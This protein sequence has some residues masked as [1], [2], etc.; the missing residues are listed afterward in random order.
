MPICCDSSLSLCTRARAQLREGLS[1]K[2]FVCRVCFQNRRFSWEFLAQSVSPARKSCELQPPLWLL[3]VS[4]RSALSL[5]SEAT[6]CVC[7]A[8][9]NQLQVLWYSSG[10]AISAML[11]S[12][13]P[14]VDCV[15]MLVPSFVP[16][17]VSC[18]LYNSHCVRVN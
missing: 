4:L 3:A 18:C 17:N 13:V 6:V 7:D 2:I 5:E 8:R 10:Q 12:Q 1:N 15:S 9:D 14:I 16:S 11:R